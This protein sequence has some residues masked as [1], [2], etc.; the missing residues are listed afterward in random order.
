METCIKHENDQPEWKIC[1]DRPFMNCEKI[2]PTKQKYVRALIDRL[3]PDED[4]EQII[5]FGSSVTAACNPW[6]DVDLYVEM[7]KEKRRPVLRVGIPVDYWTNFLV[8]E[9]LY[10]EIMKK[11]VKVYEREQA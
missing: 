7:K 11:G 2:F 4:V 3:A 10:K 8:D 6:S 5:V 1:I 9:D